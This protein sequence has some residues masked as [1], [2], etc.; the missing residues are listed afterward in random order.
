M[1]VRAQDS[2]HLDQLRE[3]V[4]SIAADLEQ[5]YRCPNIPSS[6]APRVYDE[7]RKIDAFA[8]TASGPQQR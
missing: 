4:R 3:A 1:A 7:D 8:S 6:Y 2:L 5:L